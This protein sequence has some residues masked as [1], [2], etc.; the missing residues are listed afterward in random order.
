MLSLRRANKGR[1]SVSGWIVTFLLMLFI[2]ALV[3]FNQTGQ[4]VAH[5]SSLEPANEPQAGGFSQEDNIS[6]NQATI[7]RYFQ[8][9][10]A[11]SAQCSAACAGDPK[12][13]AYTYVR[14]GAYKA[15]DPPMCYL[16]SA[17][18]E[19]A[20]SSCCVSGVKGGQNVS[21]GTLQYGQDIADGGDYSVSDLSAESPELCQQKCAD[22][23]RCR[24][25]A[26]VKPGT[27]NYPR[28]RC[29]LKERAGRFVANA[30]TV[31]AVKDGD[32]TSRATYIGCFK[33]TPDRDLVT[34]TYWASGDMT[35]ERCVSYCR[36]KG[37]AY[38]GVQS[39]SQCFCGNSY[40]KHGPSNSCALQC[41]GNPNE[42]CGGEWTNSI[43]KVN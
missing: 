35:V 29:W 31:S 10:E 43:Y 38:A 11:S 1:A 26:Y 3:V 25:F 17:M 12:C 9:R 4:T 42:I 27:Y 21:F 33:D 15:G 28:P 13:V 22:D 32:N 14:P 39:H 34:E 8:L 24:A 41:R 7:I 16:F 37:Y 5:S 6:I 20:S 36:Q 19:R 18:G 23:P 30:N 40:G 2:A